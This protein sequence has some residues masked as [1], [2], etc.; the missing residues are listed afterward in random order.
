MR[1]T[2]PSEKHMQLKWRLSKHLV[3]SGSI[4]LDFPTEGPNYQRRNRP[5]KL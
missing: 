5:N 4:P 2:L 3:D 1:L